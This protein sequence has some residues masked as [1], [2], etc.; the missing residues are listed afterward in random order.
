MPETETEPPRFVA[1]LD[2][3]VRLRGFVPVEL[4]ARSSLGVVT[5]ATVEKPSAPAI[6]VPAV[7][8]ADR[9]TQRTTLF[10]DAE[11]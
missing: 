1:E 11:A 6:P 7:D 2:P 5:P 10:G 8:P 3:G 4:T 9:W